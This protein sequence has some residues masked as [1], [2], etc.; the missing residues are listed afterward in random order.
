M[1]ESEARSDGPE[2]KTWFR[3]GAGLV[4]L[5][6]LVLVVFS[7]RKDIAYDFFG[8]RRIALAEIVYFL[9]MAGYG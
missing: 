7:E 9:L 3:Y 6:A 4:V 1:R 5:G 8:P 2:W